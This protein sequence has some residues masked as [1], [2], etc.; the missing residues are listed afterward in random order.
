MIEQLHIVDFDKYCPNCKHFEKSEA[1]S[2]CDDCLEVSARY[3]S[4]KPER[5]EEK[6]GKN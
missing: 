2:P 1:E 3:G 6:D 4:R 5:W